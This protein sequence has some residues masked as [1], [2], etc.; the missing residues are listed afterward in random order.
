M[1]ARDTFAARFGDDQATAI[2]QAA[3][4]HYA[5]NS[6]IMFAVESPDVHGD[7]RFG[8]DPFKYWFLLAIGYECVTRPE[9][10]EEHGIT[11]DIEEMK[12]WARTDG[13]L[14]GHDGDLPDFLAAMLGAYDGWIPQEVE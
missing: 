1:T 8:S 13:D 5:S 14:E 11:A 6:T 12:Q 10:R 3:Q 2:E 9:F 7:D 4:G